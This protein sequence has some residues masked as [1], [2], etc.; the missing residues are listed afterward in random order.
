MLLALLLLAVLS[1][2][3]SGLKVSSSQLREDT[4]SVVV[5]IYGTP[6]HAAV[7]ANDA[8]IV[9]ALLDAKANPNG[10]ELL[11]RSPLYYAQALAYGNVSK[12]LKQA[13]AKEDDLSAS[14]FMPDTLNKDI[15][16]VGETDVVRAVIA[17]N[18]DALKAI[19]VQSPDLNTVHKLKASFSAVDGFPY[20]ITVVSPRPEE[21]PK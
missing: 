18:V 6:L 12:L 19:S 13:G 2:A 1:A 8:R 17:G 5:L 11:N 3:S 15:G 10:S 20:N 21:A 14:A 9:A 4:K 16:A 7:L